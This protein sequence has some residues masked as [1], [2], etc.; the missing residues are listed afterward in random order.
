MKKP[1][2][3]KPSEDYNR[4]L[5]TNDPEC[6]E[7]LI[8]YTGDGTAKKAVPLD[9]KI[10]PRIIECVNARSGKD[11]VL[12][13]LVKLLV[14]EQPGP[15]LWC[16]QEVTDERKASGGSALD[17]AS[18]YPDDMGEDFGCG[19]NPISGDGG[20]GP[21]LRPR[22]DRMIRMELLTLEPSDRKDLLKELE[23]K[24]G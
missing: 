6:P 1:L 17:W 2:T 7:I 20:V 13:K 11:A 9:G 16:D 18:H 24:N 22:D 8:N 23:N 15:C 14:R 5:I 4:R 19:D 3:L 21:H 10:I 12:E